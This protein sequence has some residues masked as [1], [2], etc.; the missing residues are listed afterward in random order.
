MSGSSERDSRESLS[1]CRKHFERRQRAAKEGYHLPSDEELAFGMSFFLDDL[2]QDICEF[3]ARL[4]RKLKPKSEDL[5]VHAVIHRLQE[6]SIDPDIAGVRNLESALLAAAGMDGFDA[7]AHRARCQIYLASMGSAEDM[8]ALARKLALRAVHSLGT[9]MAAQM[10]WRALGWLAVSDVYV[11]GARQGKRIGTSR[12]IDAVN[13]TERE[14]R[15]VAK[16]H[17]VAREAAER[18]E[19]TESQS[20]NKGDKKATVGS[21]GVVVFSAVGNAGIAEGKKIAKEFEDIAGVAL[22]LPAM[23]DLSVARDRLIDEFPYAYNVIDR[24]LTDLVGKEHVRVRPTILVGA[25]GCG[26]TRFAQRFFEELALPFGL[27]PCGGLSDS[28]IAGT[29]RRWSSGEP[30]L[31]ASFIMRHRCA[32]PGI[33]LDEIE[34]VGSSRHNGNVHDALLGLIGDETA[35]RWFDPYIQS[36]CDFSNV[37]WLMTANEAAGMSAPLRDRC[38]LIEFPNPGLRHLPAIANRVLKVVYSDLGYDERW[39]TPLD[40]LELQVLGR[41]WSGGSIREL[42]RMVEGLVEARGKLERCH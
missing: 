7:Q 35:G 3:A 33:I 19:P 37:S 21:V 23:V 17:L 20:D 11:E 4:E 24:L 12:L 13:E 6:M 38:R 26:K 2:E 28:S 27:I 8:V 32:G 5:R 18:P 30:S 31:P 42:T 22:P 1:R 40:G 9:D 16:E 39:A 15:L 25:P 14:L 34:K 41:A 10:Q 29:P 36:N